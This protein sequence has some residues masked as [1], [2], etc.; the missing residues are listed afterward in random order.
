MGC[1]EDL[2]K[3]YRLDIIDKS[4]DALI[5]HNVIMVDIFIRME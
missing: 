3:K 2:D 4:I 5:G 1:P